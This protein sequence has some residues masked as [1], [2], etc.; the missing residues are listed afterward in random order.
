MSFSGL[1]KGIFPVM[2]ILCVRVKINER[3][4]SILLTPMSELQRSS[5]EIVNA[6]TSF[7][8]F[9]QVY[10]E[11][12]GRTGARN[13]DLKN[14]SQQTLLSRSFMEI[15]WSIYLRRISQNVDMSA[16]LMSRRYETK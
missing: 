1:T 4:F 7:A 12:Y 6:V 13:L 9:K 16:E 3:S 14:E 2:C 10:F 8:C 11:R 15:I 5:R